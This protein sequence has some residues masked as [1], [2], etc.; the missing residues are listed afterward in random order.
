[1][2]YITSIITIIISAVTI[3]KNALVLVVL[4][5]INGHI[6]KLTV[7]N[8]KLTKKTLVAIALSS[9]LVLTACG[10][11]TGSNEAKLS[12][13]IQQGQTYL[14]QHQF[15]AAMIA[16]NNAIS[17]YPD[18]IDGYLVLAKA[19]NQLGQI[20]P[21][22]DVLN[23]YKN[24]KNTEYYFLQLDAYHKSNKL[25]SANKLIEK[26]SQLLQQQPERLLLAQANILLKKQQP[27][28][29][30]A[31][32]QRLE[33]SEKYKID[34]MI[35]LARVQA[36][37]QD[38]EG[39]ISTLD[40]VNTLD[41]NNT[42]SL[43]LQ[44]Y[45]YM[46]QGNSA[47]AETSLSDA[48][49]IIPSADMFTPERINILQSLTEV[50][51]SQG[52]SSEALLYSRILAEE[53]P[54]AESIN[55]QYAQASKF[56]NNRQLTEAKNTLEKILQIAPGYKKAATLLGVILY[57]QGD[58]QGAEKY[59]S[60]F[61]DPETNP[62]KLTQLYAMT[63]LKLDQAA[64]VLA[65]LDNTIEEETAP[66]TLGLYAI[67]AIN[68]QAF[69]KAEF[70]LNKMAKLVPDSPRLALIF[71]LYYS[72]LPNP[73]QEKSL[74]ILA[75]GL[76]I[77]ASDQQLQVAYIKQLILLKQ[78]KKADKYV[79]QLAKKAGNDVDRLLLVANYNV[80]RKQFSEAEKQF[81]HILTISANQLDALYGLARVNQL[82]QDW[83]AT[84]AAYK[85]VLSHYPQEIK[86]YQGIVLSLVKLKQD[87]EQAQQ[88]LPQNH[89]SAIWALVLA[90]YQAKN[91]NFTSAMAYLTKADIALPDNLTRYAKALRQQISYQRASAA[92]TEGDFT[93]ARQVTLKNIKLAPQQVRFVTL[94]AH[95]EIRSG[96]YTEAEK[97]ISQI[98]TIIPTSPMVNI[99][100]A[101]LALAQNNPQQAAKL[102]H[103]EWQKNHD[104]KVARKLYVILKASDQAGAAQ[105][106]TDWRQ[107]APKSLAASLNQ[108]LELQRKR[109]NKQAVALYEIILQQAP[110]EIT[111]LNNAAWLYLELAD[112]RAI[113][114]A[115]RAYKIAPENGNVLDTYGWILFKSGQSVKAKSMI[116]KATHLLPG[117][118][119]IQQHWQEINA[120]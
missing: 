79:K 46:N 74:Q 32:F 40:E 98:S 5:D 54:G 53:F 35:G 73:Q 49:S 70:A 55:Q 17:A 93:T 99:L 105:F 104:D 3:I 90:S 57:N 9:S 110:N 86:P 107:V 24:E 56:Y 4:I 47:L 83:P 67:A 88:H 50:L 66:E 30:K 92:L 119:G 106:L 60:G 21:S 120:R 63:Q 94:L 10:D 69:D 34:G 91:N 75:N 39:A 16:A 111:S 1:M 100:S 64:D 109:Q 48:L 114:L 19:Y 37:S 117:D 14:Q 76:K 25:I 112:S 82:S 87:P 51:T 61:I 84:L 36:L 58:M 27:E 20:A 8:Y 2:T 52:R 29:A 33:S 45:L 113:K 71:S 85:N 77:N 68:Q 115:E 7:T 38:I 18:Q 65:M 72:S 6:M 22:L 108:A 26:Q 89:D 44:S 59:L 12:Q 62:A 41:P 80:H 28:Q 42:E 15:K 116:E 103:L 96:Q 11:D 95:I 78:T 13:H 31:I 101:E 118:T 81:K 102:L 43:I 23:S 97:V